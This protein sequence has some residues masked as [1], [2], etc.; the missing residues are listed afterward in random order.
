MLKNAFF[1][2]FILIG[3]SLSG[4]N[5]Y[6][7]VGSISHPNSAFKIFLTHGGKKDSAILKNGKFSF[8]GELDKTIKATIYT[9][10]VNSIEKYPV[11]EYLY[12]YLSEGTTKIQAFKNVNSAV[13]KGGIEQDQYAQLQDSLLWINNIYSNLSGL[14][15]SND[16]DDSTK[17]RLRGLYKILYPK[18]NIIENNFIKAH[19]GSIV[20]WDIVS[21]RGVIIDPDPLDSVFNFLSKELQ[22][23]EKGTIL[24][25]RI[26]KAKSLKIGSK[27]I[28]FTINDQA[29]NPVSL[30]SFK[31]KYVLIDF[32]ASWCGPCRAENPNM[33]KA[34][35]SLKESNFEIF[36][37]SLDDKR[38]NWLKAVA[39]DKLPWRQVSDLKGF[40]TIAK[41]YDI[42]AIPQNF[43]IDADGKIIAKN[44]RGESMESV[45]KKHMG[46]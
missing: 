17:M 16:T 22:A 12:F 20:S 31:G 23:S 10:A 45:I 34:Y 46:L 8:K 13:V 42:M 26:E 36:G 30:S 5:K 3:N 11:R 2:I 35:N 4:Q 24:K 25:A 21:N 29:G 38:E 9:Q 33:V 27:A 40:N 39:E 41:V 15:K 18:V 37:V 44:I 32:W 28:D 6:Q 7:I 43:L 19:S 1:Y 14:L